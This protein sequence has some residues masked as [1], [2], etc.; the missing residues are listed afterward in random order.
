MLIQQQVVV[1]LLLLALSLPVEARRVG[2][3]TQEARLSDKAAVMADQAYLVGEEALAATLV[4]AEQA[5]PTPQTLSVLP[6]LRERVALVVAEAVLATQTMD[7]LKHITHRALAVG[8]AC[9]ERGAT[10]QAV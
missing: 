9:L 4:K 7:T 8:S 10:A 6:V 1:A 3:V 2:L 5:G